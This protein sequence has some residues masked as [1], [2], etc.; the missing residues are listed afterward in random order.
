MSTD[1]IK[2][3]TFS[4]SRLRIGKLPILVLFFETIKGRLIVSL[5]ALLTLVC[6][7][8]FSVYYFKSISTF[9]LTEANNSFISEK[10][11]KKGNTPST[12]IINNHDTVFHH[13]NML[14]VLN[15]I[16]KEYNNSIDYKKRILELE[17]ELES[18]RRK[19]ITISYASNKLTDGQVIL[20]RVQQ[21]KAATNNDGSI[22]VLLDLANKTAKNNEQNLLKISLL[23]KENKKLR[24]DLELIDGQNEQLFIQLED[25]ISMSIG[26]LKKMFHSLE[27]PTENIIQHIKD[28][29]SGSGGPFTLDNLKIDYSKNHIENSV[30]VGNEL[31]KTLEEV[32]FYRIAFEK[33]PFFNPVQSA[34]RFTSGFGRR[35]DPISGKKAVHYGADFAAPKGTPIYATADGVITHAGWRGGYGLLVV[36]KH[37]FGFETRY[38]HNSRIRVKVGQKVSRGDQISDMGSTGRSTGTHLHYEVRRNNKPLNPMTYIKVGRNV[39]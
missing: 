4:F 6:L 29:Y 25:A 30:Y 35:N 10:I 26:P 13:S 19:L 7:I 38:A 1:K 23:E 8:S 5:S 15:K 2:K 9:S 21:N 3:N 37:S 16:D 31:L 12:K 34:N 20:K 27:L 33:L 24:R 11:Q 32:N 17:S 36:I 28:T 39:F 22:K 14:K 18:V